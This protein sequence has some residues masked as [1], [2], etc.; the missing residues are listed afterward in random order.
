MRYFYKTFI[1]LL[2]LGYSVVAQEHKGPLYCNASLLHAGESTRAAMK[3][4]TLSLPF[5]EDFTSYDL[6]PD[7]TK[8]V[9]KQVYINNTMCLNPISRGVATFDALNE[10]GLPWNTRSNTAFGP[11]DT[12]TSRPIDLSTFTPGDSLYL[13]FYYQPQGNGFY[14]LD[15]DSLFLFMRDLAGNYFKVWRMPGSRVKPFT[16]VMIPITDSHFFHNTFQFRFINIAALNYSDAIWNLD[17]IKLDAHRTIGDTIL[18]DAAFSADPTFLLNDYTSM[19]YR[20][21]MAS[22][23]SERTA[24]LRS[25]LSNNA[26]AQTV[27]HHMSASE[28]ATGIPLQTLTTGTAVLPAFGPQY[29]IY[30]TY[31]NTVT[32]SSPTAKVVFRDQYYIE[33]TTT[34]GTTNNDTIIKDQVFDN[35]LAYDDGTAEQ[36]YYLTLLPTLPGKLQIEYHLNTPDTLRGMAIYFGRQVPSA[37]YKYFDIQIFSSLSGVMGATSDNLIYQQFSCN[38]GYP[39]TINHFWI[40]KFDNPVA[41]SAGTF[42]AGI[43]LPA[44]SGADSIY[45]GLDMN[46]IG[47]NHAYFNVLSSWTASSVRGAIMMRPLLGQ[48][49][50]SSEIKEV[51]R[52]TVKQWQVTPN[53]AS[54]EITLNFPGDEVADFKVTD[55]SGKT[56]KSGRAMSG[57]KIDIRD[58]PQGM[59]FVHL[60]EN[61]VREKPQKLIKL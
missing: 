16:Q 50:T 57:G 35:Y 23:A 8:W 2:L 12:L 56:V 58:L 11:A 3:K 4:T 54:D 30:N 31:T 21:F 40:Y 37:A 39:D 20:Q 61:G 17:Y 5:F 55:L 15:A 44:E 9:E 25:F 48:Q 18:G 1:A 45:F 49:I 52:A 33:S 27:T 14:P 41:L 46:R 53:P 22:P 6:Y 19:P 51:E 7:N 47:P 13:S 10:L 24:R 32:A 29:Q 28:L 43:F 36:S 59:Y 60:L 26:A 42:Y 38:P 34:T